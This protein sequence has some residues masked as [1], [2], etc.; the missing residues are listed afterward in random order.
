MRFDL[1]LIV[2]TVFISALA[3][4]APARPAS[5]ASSGIGLDDPRSNESTESDSMG[6]G[7]SAPRS[8]APAGDLVC[9]ASSPDGRTEL[10]LTWSG[11]DATG[12][13]RTIGPSGAVTDT[14]VR[15]ERNKSAIIVD[16]T[17]STDLATHLATVVNDSGKRRIRVVEMGNPRSAQCD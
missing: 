7:A 11:T 8:D 13:L 17:S 5:S 14:R 2:A 16:E 9:R 10:Y 6:G 1:N 3:A 4:C 15:A 12:V